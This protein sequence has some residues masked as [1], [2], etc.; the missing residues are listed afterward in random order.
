[1]LG[2]AQQWNKDNPDKEQIDIADLKS[3]ME[4]NMEKIETHLSP[5]KSDSKDKKKKEEKKEKKIKASK[6]QT[7]K[8]TAETPAP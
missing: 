6:E 7:P 2:D 8:E 1:M 4:S 3:E 5:K